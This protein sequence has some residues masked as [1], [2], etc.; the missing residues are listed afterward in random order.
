MALEW[1]HVKGD[2][3]EV[4][5]DIDRGKVR[6]KHRQ[7]A[8]PWQVI[9]VTPAIKKVL[10]E[11]RA[12]GKQA[13]HERRATA[14][15]AARFLFPSHKSPRGHLTSEQHFVEPLARES[16]VFFTSSWTRTA[17]VRLIQK[18][19]FSKA[20]AE[21]TLNHADSRPSG[22]AID[23]YWKTELTKRGLVLEGLGKEL[24]RLAKARL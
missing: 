9:P 17:A 21:A 11:I 10:D 3:I 13:V 18:A 4:P 24:A 15:Q 20:D 1:E 23:H 12:A 22:D 19:G 7:Q 14:E 5:A 2:R 8:Q 6:M 16:G